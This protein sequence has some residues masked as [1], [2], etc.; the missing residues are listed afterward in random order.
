MSEQTRYQ[1]QDRRWFPGY[2]SD[3][4]RRTYLGDLCLRIPFWRKLRSFA[5]GT[6]IMNHAQNE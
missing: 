3:P 2:R 5:Q 1:P 4:S 6:E